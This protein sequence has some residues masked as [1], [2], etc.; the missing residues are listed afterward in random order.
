MIPARAIKR[1]CLWNKHLHLVNSVNS[2]FR[3]SSNS[4]SQ[5]TESKP[6][7]NVG[8]IGHVDHGKTTLS[9]AITRVLS[10]R[11]LAQFR[12]YQQID[13]LPEE[14]QRGITINTAM[15]C[16]DTDSRSYSH[17]DCPGHADYVKNMIAG[18]RTLG[19]VT[20]IMMVCL[21]K[22]LFR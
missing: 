3:P 8:T 22:G 18:K 14:Q 21:F 2:Q 17:V 19:N 12:S 1:S 11:G 20:M 10:D 16:Y 9:A 4:L 7:I 5:N 13:G 6:W 15:L